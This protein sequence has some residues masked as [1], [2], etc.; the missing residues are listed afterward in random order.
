MAIPVGDISRVTFQLAGDSDNLGYGITV[1]SAPDQSSGGKPREGGVDDLHLGTT[2]SF[3]HCATCGLDKQTCIG[4]EGIIRL[5][6]PV[7]NPIVRE[8]LTKWLNIIC[9]SC[10]GILVPERAY[11]GAVGPHRFAAAAAYK[12]IAECPHCGESQSK[13]GLKNGIHIL[14]SDDDKQ[15]YPHM[16]KTILSRVQ[17]KDITALGKNLNSHPRN[18][19][20]SNMII[21]PVITRPAVRK[22]TGMRVTNSDITTMMRLILTK[23]QQLPARI[24]DRVSDEYRKQINELNMLVFN[25][26]RGGTDGNLVSYAVSMKS[27]EGLLRKNLLGKRCNGMARSTIIGDPTIPIDSLGI[28]MHFARTIDVQE[29]VREQNYDRLISYV[30][31]GRGQYPGAV[32]VIKDGTKIRTDIGHI[33]PEDIRMGDIICRNVIDGDFALFNRQPTLM[34][35][36]MSAHRIIVMRDPDSYPI[37]MNVCA[38]PWYNAD[39]DGD[40]MNLIFVSAEYARVELRI[41]SAAKNW[42]VSYSDSSPPIGQVDDGVIGSAELT[43][44]TT[45]MDRYHAMR[46]F[47]NTQMAPIFDKDTYSGRDIIT[48]MLTDTPVNFQ[49][50]PVSVRDQMAPYMN[51]SKS[52][53]RV[54]IRNGVMESGI[55]DKSSIGKGA[56]GGLYHVMSNEHGPEVALRFMHDMQKLV[57]AYLNAVGYSIGLNDIVLPDSAYDEISRVYSRLQEKAELL[58]EDLY[59]GRIVPSF[60]QT[61]E[62]MYE[63]QIVETLKNPDE[64]YRIVMTNI[65]PRVNGLFKLIL[66]GSKGNPDQMFNMMVSVGQK[67]L[68]NARLPLKF[69]IGRAS[70]YSQRFS[71]KPIDRGY[72]GNSLTVGMNSHEFLSNASASRLD[73]II[74]ALSTSITGEMNRKS[75]ICLSPI[76][77]DNYMRSVK[78]GIILQLAF[79]DNFADV[80]YVEDISFPTVELSDAEMRDRYRHPDY[81]AFFN[82]MVEDRN[83]YRELFISLEHLSKKPDFQTSVR[84]L[85]NLDRIIKNVLESTPRSKKELT[86]T[87]LRD[88]MKFLKEAVSL[89]PYVF[90]N[91]IMERKRVKVLPHFQAAAWLPQ[92]I[93]RSL[94]NPST[95]TRDYM[96]VDILKSIFAQVKLKMKRSIVT[97]GTPIGIIAAQSFSEPLT[98]YMLDAHHRS[99]V[100]G[101]SFAAM[102]TVKSVIEAK[103][104]K[105]TKHTSMFIRVKEQYEEDERKVT[106]IAN[107][108]EITHLREFVSRSQIFMEPFGKPRHPDYRAEQ[109]DIETYL[110]LNPLMK[111][112]ADLSNWCIR[113]VIDKSKIILKDMPVEAMVARLRAIYPEYFIV[114]TPETAETTMLR[115][116]IRSNWAGQTLYL[117]DVKSRSEALLNTTIRG[118][119][120]IYGA[121]TIPIKRHYV[122]DD[123][124]VKTKQVYA[125]ET[126]GT[127]II[128]VLNHP[129]VDPQRVISNSV[130]EMAM[131]Y[132]IVAA[133]QQIMHI[134][135]D[136]VDCN[137]CHLS[138]YADEMTSTGRVTAITLPGANIR[139]HNN[140]LLRMGLASPLKSV[141]DGAVRGAVNV[142]G[143][144]MSRVLVGGSPKL[145]TNFNQ[146]VV[147]TEFVRQN[148]KSPDEII[149]NVYT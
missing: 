27:K 53:S 96:T 142:V 76:V 102:D 93:I 133:R 139:E 147:D 36:N 45:T 68:N 65:N 127:N 116:Y 20:L 11:S 81:P 25:C 97:P 57:I 138:L 110:R 16:I 37:R 18:Y 34:I 31:N 103:E 124:G 120:D 125:I 1:I 48:L 3:Y 5:N 129:G 148:I 100:G 107:S 58:S 29:T 89:I 146:Y 126:N 9:H 33:N 54:V 123:G 85:F 64:F 114:Y 80:R 79:G 40:A 63:A 121:K 134:L 42:L 140:I 2:D 60:G 8:E 90:M 38:T 49:R 91:G 99:A 77:A 88:S 51:Y 26:F 41:L 149:G 145:G 10:G 136:I 55:L 35:S 86:S 43:A 23:N 73:L 22:V 14:I 78:S 44:D 109:S 50:T 104:T 117:A 111:P 47:D 17:D 59:N 66:T 7:I 122:A 74:K 15:L 28:P 21:P 46:L 112:P 84:T 56:R 19:V 52:E 69:G 32:A 118:V 101:S 72:I 108:I 141:T 113:M 30:R 83:R 70:A 130:K 12:H 6:Y 87:Q 4:H 94:I 71:T 144:M 13:V 128:K 62:S 39:F 92:M 143:D 115:I 132:G 98:Q 137:W 67:L 135:H 24:P 61:I 119:A 82:E 106:E 75:T 131:V 105:A 95:I